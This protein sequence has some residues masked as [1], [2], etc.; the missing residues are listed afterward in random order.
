MDYH[1]KSS[2]GEMVFAVVDGLVI[3]AVVEGEEWWN[4]PMRAIA[5][6]QALKF[7]TNQH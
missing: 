1:I 2:V 3:V 5:S 4:G 7:Q 6:N